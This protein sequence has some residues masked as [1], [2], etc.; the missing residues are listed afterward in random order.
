MITSQLTLS[1]SSAYQASL[2]WIEKYNYFHEFSFLFKYF[3]I[4][5][6]LSRLKHDLIGYSGVNEISV[7]YD[8]CYVIHTHIWK[9]E[10]PWMSISLSLHLKIFKW[11]PPGQISRWLAQTIIKRTVQHIGNTYTGT[12][13][14]KY[15][16]S[17][18]I[19]YALWFKKM[20]MSFSWDH[21]DLCTV[22]MLNHRWNWG[23]HNYVNLNNEIIYTYR[24]RRCAE[25]LGE[26]WQADT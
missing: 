14:F 17:T 22:T 25:C 21:Q 26:S 20:N 10:H 19:Y 15:V 24:V 4:Y 8:Y 12:K 18:E 7:A 16:C 13:T 2:K 23:Q 5:R 9:Y 6:Y 11:K 1:V 3:M